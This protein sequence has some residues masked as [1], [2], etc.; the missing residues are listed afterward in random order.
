[1]YDK[2]KLFPATAMPDSDWWQALWPNPS[3]VL[4]AIG[5]CEG[6]VAIDLCCGDGL[7]TV[8]LSILLNGR[9]YAIDIDPQMLAIA[10]QAL[11]N[12]EAPNCIW[13][14]GDAREM[15]NLVPKKV[16]AV[17]VANT[18]HGV[19]EQT[20]MAKNAY[21]VLAPKGT[22]IV[23]NWHV[24][25]REKTTVLGHPRGPRLDLRMSP[26]DVRDVVEPSGLVFKETVDLP[27]YH[28]GT[29]FQKP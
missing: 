24:L 29:V 28:Y 26:D 8:P 7:F 19:P 2:K 22:F 15:T 3:K 13:I 21:D 10:K 4:D 20:E 1:M 9:V 11:A 12:S 6:M 27:P 17:L 16:D 25:P 5:I 14:E 18:F 23:V